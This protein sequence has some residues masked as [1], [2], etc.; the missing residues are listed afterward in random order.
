MGAFSYLYAL[1]IVGSLLMEDQI[2]I[3]KL[4][5]F[6]PGILFGIANSMIFT[7]KESSTYV[8]SH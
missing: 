3:H 7:L 5:E 2:S 6:I 1:V 4:I 8:L